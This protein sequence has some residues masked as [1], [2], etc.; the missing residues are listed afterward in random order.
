MHAFMYVL[1]SI[2][3]VGRSGTVEKGDRGHMSEVQGIL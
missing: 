2:E 3:T 1:M